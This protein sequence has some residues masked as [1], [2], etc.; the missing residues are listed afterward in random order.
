MHSTSKLGID[1]SALTLIHSQPPV[2]GIPTHETFAIGVFDSKSSL[3]V[4]TPADAN[5][6]P[7]IQKAASPYTTSQQ[8]QFM[9]AKYDIPDPDPYQRGEYLWG[10]H[11]LVKA[12]ASQK[13]LQHLSYGVTGSIT[14]VECNKADENQVRC[15]MRQK[16]TLRG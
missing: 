16:V 2:G 4:D 10:W 14:L 9:C 15:Y 11:C 6:P 8:Y 3:V 13:C 1:Y 5:G 7:R 12:V